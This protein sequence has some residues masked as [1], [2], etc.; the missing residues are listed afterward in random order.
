MRDTHRFSVAPMMDYT[1]RHFRRLLRLISRRSRLYTEM[2]TAAAIT[3][4]KDVERL[5]A[6]HPTEEPL[7]L[8]LGGSDPVQLADASRQAK[9]RG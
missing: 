3:H 2:V 5:L 8:Q 1:D 6:F 4:A 9:D 7:T